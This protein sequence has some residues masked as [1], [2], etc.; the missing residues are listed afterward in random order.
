MKTLETQYRE[1]GAGRLFRLVWLAALVL[2]SGFGAAG[3]IWPAHEIPLLLVPAIL[4]GALGISLGWLGP[5]VV[6]IYPPRPTQGNFW[7]RLLDRKPESNVGQLDLF[8]SMVPD[9][10]A[11]R[12][13]HRILTDKGEIRVLHVERFLEL[14]VSRT[15]DAADNATEHA[16]AL[17]WKKCC[18]ELAPE[19]QPHMTKIFRE[20]FKADMNGNIIRLLSRVGDNIVAELVP[21]AEAVNTESSVFALEPEPQMPAPP[22]RSKTRGGRKSGER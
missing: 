13:V 17:A 11:R 1:L 15:M 2:G 10:S 21:E 8:E 3:W 19:L 6:G 22:V 18:D 9:L 16:M 5:P 4:C 7:V 12:K 20:T 14:L